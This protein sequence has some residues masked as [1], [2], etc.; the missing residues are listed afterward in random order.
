MIYKRING[1]SWLKWISRDVIS[2]RT[3]YFNSYLDQLKKKI[4]VF[5]GSNSIKSLDDFE[6]YN[7]EQD[8]WTEIQLKLK[9]PI[10]AFSSVQIDYYK[11]KF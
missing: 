1:F 8:L 6:V 10:Y 7:M 5:G 4:F 3:L 2:D 9:S 11:V